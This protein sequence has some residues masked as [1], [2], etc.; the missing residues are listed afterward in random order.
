MK[1]LLTLLAFLT[2]GC[3]DESPPIP[4]AEPISD[5]QL[6]VGT[7]SNVTPCFTAEALPLQ[8]SAVSSDTDIV[9][10]A[11]KN[12]MITIE[13]HG[14]GDAIVSI[15]ATDVNG[16]TGS[17]P[18]M[19][20]VPNRN[21]EVV[22]DLPLGNMGRWSTYRIPLD[23]Y[24]MDPDGQDLKYE[25]VIP[26]QSPATIEL[27]NDTLVL[28]S[29]HKY[30]WAE[31]TIMVTDPDGGE[32]EIKTD[33]E[34]TNSLAYITQ[35]THT[36]D[37]KYDT[38]LIEGR[39]GLLRVL[40]TANK[41]DVPMPE[42]TARLLSPDGTELDRFTLTH[43]SKNTPRGNPIGS[44]GLTPAFSLSSDRIRNRNVVEINVPETS[45]HSMPLAIRL[46]MNVV[47]PP[48][49]VIHLVPIIHNR[50][51]S[52][53]EIVKTMEANQHTDPRLDFTRR[54]L[55][56]T[57]YE[58]HIKNPLRVNGGGA[59]DMLFA[60]R[61]KWYMEGSQ[62]IYM[63][64]IPKMIGRTAGIAFVGG[65]GSPR[66]G[67]GIPENFTLVH[68]LGH[69]LSLP[70]APCGGVRSFDAGF[71]NSDGSIGTWGYDDKLEQLVNPSYRDFMGYCRPTWLS[72]YNFNKS[73]RFR[74][75]IRHHTPGPRIPV[76]IVQG[77]I[78]ADGTPRLGSSYY[79]MAPKNE[80]VPGDYSIEIRAEGQPISYSFSPNIIMDAPTE[81]QSFFHLIPVTWG[82]EQIETIRLLTPE[83]EIAR[84]DRNTDQPHSVVIR[85]GQ[86]V[87]SG[88][89]VP[90]DLLVNTE[91]ITSRGIPTR[92]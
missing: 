73:L 28:S 64:V 60:L 80:I 63:G 46:P 39:G 33:I 14:V 44:F 48:K 18:V 87:Y 41:A 9:T 1:R 43:S 67:L 15:T 24:F 72:D 68:E 88:S 51:E 23:S 83:G 61:S 7:T 31:G 57:E 75:R 38:P 50:D 16:K 25:M 5:V 19:V 21:P 56:V 91:V 59:L 45:D 8:Y 42:T 53:I 30:G 17:Q 4:C 84:M 27:V 29:H 22:E 36:P 35:G 74:N 32:L 76:L 58:F 3:R 79:T 26:D 2:L 81:T 11:A 78:E 62:N 55:P 10:V 69:I 77:Q 65:L 89:N 92:R 34:V 54:L 71:P 6:Y 82:R 90:A 37:S 13:A 12:D 85:D 66:V 52:A 49:L 47:K 70:H 86:V 20:I 40:L